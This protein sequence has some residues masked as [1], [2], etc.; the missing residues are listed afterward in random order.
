M[1]NIS[2]KICNKLFGSFTWLSRHIT[3]N[4]PDITLKEYYDNHVSNWKLNRCVVCNGEGLFINLSKGYRKTC[5][6]FCAAQLMHTPDAREKAK[7]S[8][9]E[10]YGV[11]NPVTL[12]SIRDKI[13]T[14]QKNRFINQNERRKTSVATKF[15]MMRE[16]VKQKH[17]TA[18]RLPKSPETLKKMSVSARQK[19]INDPTLKLK[20]Y[21]KIRNKKIST[22]KKTYWKL[23]PQKKERVG[24][25][26]K[27]QK[28]KMGETEWKKHL[29]RIAKI[30]FE[31]IFGNN[32]ETKLESKMYSFMDEHGIKYNKQ[33]ELDNRLFDAYLPDHN[34]LLEF[35]GEFW[36]KLSLDDC[37]YDFQRVA[38]HNDRKKDCIAKA[39]NIK[40]FRIKENDSCDRIMEIL[41][42]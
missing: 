41:K 20:I 34:I 28:E 23:N 15:A 22:H 12:K 13:S 31:K 7:K 14:T 11:S 17:L 36:H 18:V 35:D 19:F 39:H 21:T 42:K 6:R 1:K 38:F 8:C 26:W 16:D 2:C 37:K 32:G 27:Y 33:F 4:H 40:L 24:M 3:H 9:L 29:L 25:L 10:R 5:S 30:G